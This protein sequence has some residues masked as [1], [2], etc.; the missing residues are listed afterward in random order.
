M[1]TVVPFV[2]ACVVLNGCA[3]PETELAEVAAEPTLEIVAESDRQ[4]TG[5]AV[6]KTAAFS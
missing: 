2:F 5:V 6:R 1:K 3:A 4:W